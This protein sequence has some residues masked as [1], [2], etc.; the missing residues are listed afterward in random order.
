MTSTF[1]MIVNKNLVPI[2]IRLQRATNPK[3]GNNDHGLN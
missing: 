3:C 2:L 1:A